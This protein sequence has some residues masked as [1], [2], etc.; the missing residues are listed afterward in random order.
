VLL[1]GAGSVARD[2]FRILARTGAQIRIVA[3]HA[4][5]GFREEAL[6]AGA[7][8][9]LRPIRPTDLHGIQLLI[10]ATNDPDL[11]AQLAAEARQRGIWVNAV[12]DP[13][14]CD[15]YFASQLHIGPLHLA[16]SSDGELPGL[17]RALRL[18]LEELLPESHYDALEALAVLRAKLKQLP[19][20]D[21]R[22]RALRDLASGLRHI[23]LPTLHQDAS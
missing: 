21:L 18:C 7:E 17:M 10:T 3:L 11:N 8:L 12:D 23:Y 13:P 19:D 1:V 16:L 2:K 22:L 6:A 14:S 4:A 5:P 9:V 20:S 15:A